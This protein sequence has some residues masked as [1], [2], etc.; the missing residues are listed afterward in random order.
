VTFGQEAVGGIGSTT[1][2]KGRLAVHGDDLDLVVDLRFED[3][4]LEVRTRNESL[5]R[6]P[7]S[8]VQVSQLESG[9]FSLRLGT[10]EALFAAADPQGFAS[11]AIPP[12]MRGRH[13]QAAITSNLKP[14]GW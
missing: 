3:E 8:E 2:Y 14:S 13:L 5:G 7:I 12:R 1:A 6:W 11:R 10:D 4:T 9:I